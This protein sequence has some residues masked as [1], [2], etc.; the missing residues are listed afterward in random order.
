MTEFEIYG[1]LAPVIVAL[2]LIAGAFWL[3]RH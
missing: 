1:L 3:E 2:I